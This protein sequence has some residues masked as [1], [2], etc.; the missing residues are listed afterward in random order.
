M[1]KFVTL[2]LEDG[3]V[4][5]R[6]LVLSHPGVMIDTSDHDNMD[7]TGLEE[8]LGL[9]EPRRT[10]VPRHH[11]H[12]GVSMDETGHE[13]NLGLT[14]RRSTSD[15]PRHHSNDGVSMDETGHEENLALTEPRSTSDPPRHHSDDGVNVD[16]TGHEDDLG[17]TEP[18][19]TSNPPSQ[20]SG[21]DGHNMDGIEYGD[22]IASQQK[23]TNLDVAQQDGPHPGDHAAPD[24]ANTTNSNTVDGNTMDQSDQNSNGKRPHPS[25]SQS[26]DSDPPAKRLAP[27]YAGKQP[28]RVP[29]TNATKATT[30]IRKKS[31]GRRR[32]RQPT[33][34]VEYDSDGSIKSN[35][36]RAEPGNIVADFAMALSAMHISSPLTNQPTTP[37]VK[38][39]ETQVRGKAR[40]VISSQSLF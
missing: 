13:E 26:Q 21:D 33:P 31:A 10:S 6:D 4:D 29:K 34:E 14:E 38:P 23:N 8:N 3:T 27:T 7:E 2:N 1:M 11:S 12:D 32:R 15:P 39:E 30:S 18:R 36:L 28:A 19:G 25:Q 9:T 16:E 40:T 22:M 20:Y 37:S 17:L 5:P 24:E 35:V